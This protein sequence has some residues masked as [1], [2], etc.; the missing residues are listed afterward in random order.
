LYAYLSIKWVYLSAI[1]IFEIG[2]AI[3]GAA[4]SSTVLIIA[5][6]IAGVGCAGILSGTFIIIAFT[7]VAEKRPM[8]NGIL[9]GV[10]G[11]SS[12]AGPLLGGAFTDNVSWRW[13]VRGE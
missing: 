7:V 2:S 12:F 3:C 6:A 13:C 11:V 8:F 4:P 10:Y 1:A 5:R 9:G